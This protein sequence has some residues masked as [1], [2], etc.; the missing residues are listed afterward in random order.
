[1]SQVIKMM[2]ILS[3][4]DCYEEYDESDFDRLHEICTNVISEYGAVAKYGFFGRWTGPDYGG[5]IITDPDTLYGHI[6]QDFSI[7]MS[8][9][10]GVIEDE[11]EMLSEIQRY[12]EFPVPP[13]IVHPNSLYLK[14]WHH[15]G[16]NL[17]M[18]RPLKK[19]A[20]VDGPSNGESFFEWCD[21]NTMDVELCKVI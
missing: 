2:R 1:M 5:S 7:L 11:E 10:F 3:K 12:C 16:C 13:L 20:S 18:I 14:Q 21:E 9:E 15:D 8:F 6:T 4:Y 17:Y 19:E